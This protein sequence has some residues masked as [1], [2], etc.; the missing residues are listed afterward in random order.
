MS[1]DLFL[2]PLFIKSPFNYIGGKYKLLPQIFPLFPKNINI[3]VD[4]F[5]GGGNVGL[6]LF[7]EKIIL[8]DNCTQLIELYD[9]FLNYSFESI[10]QKIKLTIEKFHLSNSSKYGYEFYECNSSKG[11]SEYNKE[12]FMRLRKHYNENKDVLDLFLLI[13]FGFNNQIRFNTKG[14]YNLPCGKRDF[15]ANMQKKL[16]I[17][18]ETLK[19]KNI[20]TQNKDFR[21]FNISSLDSASFVYVDP[22]YLLAN[23]PYNENNAW[24][25]KDEL[26]LLEFLN[27]L[28]SNGIRF[29]LSNVVYHKE[30]T[31]QILLQWL[32]NNPKYNINY[33]SFNY[34]NC[35][36]QTKSSESKEV[37]ITNYSINEGEKL[38]T[39]I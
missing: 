36:Y 8:N 19:N 5:C 11:L 37:L 31:H 26:D 25:E 24:K 10:M 16:Q 2:T 33:L 4:L 23:A 13:V 17:F 22:P 1:P 38:E 39:K 6:N 12:H 34:N 3:A 7:A 18:I 28:D 21:N 27:K 14:E 35:N 30:K 15:N 20:Q 9:L 32:K 29:A